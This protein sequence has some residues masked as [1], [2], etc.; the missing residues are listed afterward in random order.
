MQW[1]DARSRLA[2]SLP[3][4]RM[5]FVDAL[6]PIEAVLRDEHLHGDALLVV[7]GWPLTLEGFLRNADAT[8]HRFSRGG[9]PFVAISAEVTVAEWTLESIL[10]GPRLRTRSRYAAVASRVLVETG[11]ELLP[12]FA[13]PHCSIALPAYTSRRAQQLLEVLG[14]VRPN[15]HHTG[16]VQ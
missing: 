15:P 1:G 16:R 14:D 4:D 13:A 7:R 6:E 5:E 12:T 3:L 2:L 9:E 10:A 11:F 8:R